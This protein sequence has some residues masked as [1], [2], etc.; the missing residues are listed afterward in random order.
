M[1]KERFSIADNL[2]PGWA[3]IG[4]LNFVVCENECENKTELG[5]QVLRV[6]TAHAPNK[7]R[8]YCSV[9]CQRQH[10]YN[11][12]LQAEYADEID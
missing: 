8:I 7:A 3:S 11:L 12:R 10:V 5:G 2:P 4:T 9:E 1:A 6:N